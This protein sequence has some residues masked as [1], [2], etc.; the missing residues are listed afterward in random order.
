MAATYG[1]KHTY[2]RRRRK[3][4]KAREKEIERVCVHRVE[5]ETAASVVVRGN[6]RQRMKGQIKKRKKQK[7]RQGG[8]D[9]S[10]TDAMIWGGCISSCKPSKPRLGSSYP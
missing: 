1:C 7:K 4:S 10:G 2:K 5:D 8:N 3:G 6:T 9:S